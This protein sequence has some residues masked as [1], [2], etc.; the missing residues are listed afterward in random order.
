MSTNNFYYYV[1][2]DQ[3]N[4]KIYAGG[5]N[6]ELGE[7]CYPCPIGYYSD[8]TGAVL[9]KKCPDGFM[10]P[11][12]SILPIACPRGYYSDNK[13]ASTDTWPQNGDTC[14][15]CPPGTY[16]NRTASTSCLPCPEGMVCQDPALMPTL[17]PSGIRMLIFFLLL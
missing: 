15:R 6:Y 14:L 12:K 17:P 8:I 10:C 1:Y 11:D 9:C 7:R 16:T 3:W 2:H 5:K 4:G 13:T